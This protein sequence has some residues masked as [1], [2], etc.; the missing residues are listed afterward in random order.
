MQPKIS[1]IIPAH[2]EENY[3]GNC[4][5]SILKEISRENYPA[6]II[7]VDNN[8]SDK[9]KKIASGYPNVKVLNEPV[10]GKP[11]ACQRGFLEAGG[12]LI[13]NIDADVIMPAG[14]LKA[15]AKEFGK[16][17]GLVCLSGPH[18][19]Y[20]TSKSFRLLN[21]YYNLA[22]YATYLSVRHILK[23][24]SVTQGG[25]FIARKEALKKIGGFNH[26]FNFYGDDADIAARLHKIG[27]VK[28]TL[29]LPVE[30]S[31]RRLAKEGVFLIAFR[32]TFE[33][34]WVVLFDEPFHKDYKVNNRFSKNQRL[35]M[36][37]FKKPSALSKTSK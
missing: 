28:F 14:W 10:L 4:L 19:F 6:E 5:D 36:E 11:R 32:Y 30:S 35:K 13:C 2:N 24:G 15:A 31:A 33:Y 16:N 17:P 34:F 21:S 29:K 18:K 25:N 9:T 22:I 20:D 8:S 7:V 3:I 23:I 12:E 1:F 26:H 27:D 37:L